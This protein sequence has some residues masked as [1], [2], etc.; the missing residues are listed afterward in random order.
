MTIF[1]VLS[2]GSWL[3]FD[4]DTDPTLVNEA[5]HNGAQL[6]VDWRHETQG[7][8]NLNR[9]MSGINLVQGRQFCVSVLSTKA[10]T[11]GG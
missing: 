3:N 5:G 10:G 4:S 2:T 7:P 9:L 1:V 8:D 11:C 6:V